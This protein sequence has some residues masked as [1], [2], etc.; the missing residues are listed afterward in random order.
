LGGG[1]NIRR[2]KMA[3]SEEQKEEWAQIHALRIKNLFEQW[4]KPLGI[5]GT[6]YSEALTKELSKC[7]D[8]PLRKSLIE[9][10]S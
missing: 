4:Q 3:S 5:D 6:D 1:Q 8:E 7:C 2:P 9:S 10:I